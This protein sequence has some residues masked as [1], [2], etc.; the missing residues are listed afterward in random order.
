MTIYCPHCSSLLVDNQCKACRARGLKL[1]S[2]AVFVDPS[3]LEAVEV[4]LDPEP[5]KPFVQ[6]LSPAKA[7]AMGL[8]L[9]EK[10]GYDQV[11]YLLSAR[12]RLYLKA[13]GG[14]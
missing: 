10:S 4:R 8:I 6:P 9:V 11:F 1:G 7:E 12:V 5:G 14:S 2:A 13:K 3:S